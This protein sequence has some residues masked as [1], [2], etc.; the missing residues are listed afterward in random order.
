MGRKRP[1]RHTPEEIAQE[2]RYDPG[3]GE[4]WWIKRGPKRRIDRPAGTVCVHRA[5]LPARTVTVDGRKYYA[6]VLAWVLMTKQWPTLTVDHI[7]RNSLNNKWSNLRLATQSEQNMNHTVVRPGLTG[8]CFHKPS[9]LWQAYIKAGGKVR[10]LGY[11]KTAEAAHNA[12]L[13]AAQRLHG[14]FSPYDPRTRRP[15]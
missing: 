15:R 11:F 6:N 7:D 12:Y 14:I 8:A 1:P 10:T 5:G 9:G 13:D 2:I 4:I 3:T